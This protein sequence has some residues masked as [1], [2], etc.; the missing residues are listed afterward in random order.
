MQG[1]Y[2]HISFTADDIRKYHEGKLTPAEMHALEKAALE[3]PFLADALEGY[4]AEGVNLPADTDELKR[5][6]AGRLEEK[7]KKV[8][9]LAA[10]SKSFGW[11]RAAAMIVAIAGAGLLIYKL[12]FDRKEKNIAQTTAQERNQDTTAATVSNDSNTR[13]TTAAAAEVKPE[14][15]KDS[16]AGTVQ[17][18]TTG[19][20]A[21]QSAPPTPAPVQAAPQAKLEEKAAEIA[22]LNDEMAAKIKADS[23]R[24]AES[25]VALQQNRSQAQ[26]NYSVLPKEDVARNVSSAAKSRRA[27]AFIQSNIFR[28][29]VTDEQN[30]PLPFANI[31]NS[32]DNVGTYSDAQGNFVLISPDSVMDVQVRSL[33]F[34]NNTTQLQNGV[35]LNKVTLKDDRSLTEIVLSNKKVNT[36]L[37]DGNMVLEEPEP[38]D[39]WSN[40]DTYL[41]NN[42]NIPETYKNRRAEGGEVELS[43]EVNQLGEPVNIKVVRSLCEVCDKEAIRLL[44]E[45]PK[46]KRKVKNGKRTTVTIPF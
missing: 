31:T 3:D 24:N 2:N 39:G 9:P 38:A 41:A 7:D 45:G 17:H 22:A 26:Y 4:A 35:A 8:I 16:P 23:T 20:T 34:E 13:T 28:G 19:Q 32:R 1:D 25:L 11:L 14:I 27:Q 10:P 29:K 21:K 12:G 18:N 44:K 30:N 46:W 5:R 33:G 43:F 42:L 15:A 40:Y 6:L 36:R 37:R